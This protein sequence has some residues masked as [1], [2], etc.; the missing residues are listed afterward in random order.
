MISSACVTGS[1]V[2]LITMAEVAGYSDLQPHQNHVE[3]EKAI[4][5]RKMGF[6]YKKKREWKWQVKIA[7]IHC[8]TWKVISDFVYMET[9]VK[10]TYEGYLLKHY[11]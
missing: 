9:F 3:Q 11:L 7:D 4:S 5:Q 8:N 2:G 1:P 10:I 6:C